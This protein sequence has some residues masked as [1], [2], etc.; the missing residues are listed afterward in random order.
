MREVDHRHHD[1][2]VLLVAERL[3]SRLLRPETCDAFAFELG[4]PLRPGAKYGIDIDNAFGFQAHICAVAGVRIVLDSVYHLCPN[5][6]EVDIADQLG[7]IARQRNPRAPGLFPEPFL[8][9]IRYI[10]GIGIRNQQ[11]AVNGQMPSDIGNDPLAAALAERDQAAL[12]AM[13]ADIVPLP[14]ETFLLRSENLVGIDALRRS[15]DP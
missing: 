13:D 2:P 9:V 6:V 8:F 7:E 11:L 15:L 1:A 3:A 12:A 5:G 14:R 4:A 10:I